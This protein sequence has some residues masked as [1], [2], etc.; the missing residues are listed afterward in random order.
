MAINL[1]LDTDRLPIDVERGAD[2]G[3][4]FL[5]IIQTQRSG[6]EI[7]IPVWT[8]VRGEW[9]ISYGIQLKEDL[10]AVLN[11]FYNAQGRAAAFLFRDWSDYEIGDPANP[12][13]DRDPIVAGDGATLTRQIFKRYT[14]TSGAFFDRDITRPVSGTLSV[15]VNGVLQVEGG[16][17]DYTVDYTTGIITFAVAPP[18][19]HAIEVACEFD[20][21]VRFDT[22]RLVISMATFEA[23]EI[24]AIRIVQ[25][26]E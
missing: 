16:G 13:L 8:I 1:V 23:G 11:L 20:I 4:G 18:N 2:G 26:K 9:D 19:G 6:S 5:T 3:P 21:L 7:R 14:L 17:S 24:P 22:D 25:V 15:Y 10:D 12:L